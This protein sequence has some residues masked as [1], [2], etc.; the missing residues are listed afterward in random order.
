VQ[1]APRQQQQIELIWI[2]KA[3]QA[4][5]PVLGGS[6]RIEVFRFEDQVLARAVL[7]A[8]DDGG[9]INRT[10]DGTLLGVADPLATACMELM[11]VR[12]LASANGGKGLDGDTDQAEL[13]QP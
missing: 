13:K 9:G 7:I 2:D 11:E 6:Q 4:Q 3:L 10:V 1:A 8:L 12:H 5:G